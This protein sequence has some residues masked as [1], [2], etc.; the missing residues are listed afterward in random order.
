VDRDRT[1]PH[2]LLTIAGALLGAAALTIGMVSL[3][4][5]AS[6]ATSV[7]GMDVSGYQGN[8]NWPAAWNN[9]ARFAYVKATEGTGYTNPYFA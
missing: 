6:A 3:A 4:A 1:R 9:G 7:K 5:P 8:V 2:R